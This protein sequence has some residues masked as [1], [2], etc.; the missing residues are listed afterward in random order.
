M[1]CANGSNKPVS[2]FFAATFKIQKTCPIYGL[3]IVLRSF[4][5]FKKILKNCTSDLNFGLL[6]AWYVQ[7]FRIINNIS[8]KLFKEMQ[9]YAGI[10]E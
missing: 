7:N 1:Y 9:A 4:Q 2:N 10:V 5:Y 3:F 6:L 8:D